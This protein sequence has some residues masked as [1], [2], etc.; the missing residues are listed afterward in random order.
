[1]S[2]DALDEAGALTFG[3]KEIFWEV[4]VLGKE[5][6]K[7]LYA[8]PTPIN[9]P[10]RSISDLRNEKWSKPRIWESSICLFWRFEI[11]QE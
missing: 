3:S 7:I 1:M 11:A 9:I 5:I 2:V 10:T 8:R 4:T 6:K